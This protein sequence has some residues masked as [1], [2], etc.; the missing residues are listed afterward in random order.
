VGF[1]SS[2]LVAADSGPLAHQAL[3]GLFAQA[4]EGGQAGGILASPIWL[5]LMMVV[6]FYFLLWRPQQ[7]QAKEHRAMLAGLKKGDVVVTTGGMVAKIHSV[8][9]KF[10]VLELARDV[11]VRVLPN[12]IASKAP[13]GLLE[14][15]EP[16][17][18]EA[19]SNKEKD[20]EK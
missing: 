1:F 9:Q 14:E 5:I 15:A 19:K 8:A 16:K 20:K 11:R 6:I 13:E 2:V 4:A 17:Q 3:R 18:D 10:I 12:S 7:K